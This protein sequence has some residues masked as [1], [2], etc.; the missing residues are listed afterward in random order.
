M[1]E[2]YVVYWYR[3][4]EH[5]NP[6]CQGYIGITNNFNRRHKEHMRAVTNQVNGHFYNAVRKY[7]QDVVIHQILHTCTKEEAL[8]LEYSYR[9][10]TDIGW[11]AAIGGENTLQSVQSTPVT[12]YH[13]DNPHDLRNFNSIVE[14]ATVLN[15]SQGRIRQAVH[16][17]KSIYGYDGWAILFDPN[18]D[19][20]RT[21]T[22][23]EYRS[24]ALKGV[25]KYKPSHFKG[26]TNRW[27][28]EDKQR[29]S[30]QHKGK[31]ISLEHRKAVS[32]KNRLNTNLCK[33]I[34]LAHEDDPSIIYSFHCISEAARQLNLPLSRLKSKAQRPLNRFGKD[35]W[36]ITKLGSE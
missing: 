20:T 13:K 35:G 30:K 33:H 21:M 4:P 22:I 16:R 5:S 3:L 1:S 18:Y 23:S 10:D 8:D 9:S 29:I 32:E 25:T 7:G 31:T 17:G 11:N 12:L 19:V 15:L 2:K 6:Y 28:E 14:A 36:A 24:L 26:V 34:E 27:S